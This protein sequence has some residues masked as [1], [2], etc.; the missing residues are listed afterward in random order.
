[1][2]I[3]FLSLFFIS[4]IFSDTNDETEGQ[5]LK[6]SKGTSDESDGEK[7]RSEDYPYCKYWYDKNESDG[8][9]ERRPEVELAGPQ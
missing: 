4:Q 3:L 8:H 2:R 9:R 6:S 1:M 5:R 7:Y